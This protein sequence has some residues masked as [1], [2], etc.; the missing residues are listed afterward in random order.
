M[1]RL[2]I[3]ALGL[4][5]LLTLAILMLV[6]WDSGAKGVVT[7]ILDVAVGFLFLSWFFGWHKRVS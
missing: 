5:G 7:A 1:S 3:L 6:F 2:G 4:A